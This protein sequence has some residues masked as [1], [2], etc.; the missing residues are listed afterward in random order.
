[1]AIEN[2]RLFEDTQHTCLQAIN[3]LA[4]ALEARDAYTRGHSERV[5]RFA[6]LCAEELGLDDE[7][8]DIIR[9]AALL[10]DIGKIG[11]RDD[12]LN[13]PMKL[14]PEE[15]AI[16]SKH[17]S[18]GSE[19]LGPIKFLS[20]VRQLVTH[21]HERWDG[22]GY[23]DGLKGQEIPIESRIVAVA[24]AYDAMTSA[25]AYRGRMNREDAL[26]ELKRNSGSQFDP[27]VLAVFLR[28][29]E[30]GAL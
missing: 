10:H 12:V 8:R 4:A 22:T 15:R 16:I 29:A 11:I 14:T 5:A 6:L 28:L 26:E 20:E 24:D 2:A 3:S 17:P 7:Q 21:H 30:R 27:H 23:P 18:F 19:I 13:K 9:K 1:V 25:R